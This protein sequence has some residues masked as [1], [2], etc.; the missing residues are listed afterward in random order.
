MK[1][2][3]LDNDNISSSNIKYSLEQEDY[4]VEIARSFSDSIAKLK[5]TEYDMMLLDTDVDEKNGVSIIQRLRKHSNVPLIVT[6][7]TQEPINRILAL[8]YGADDY[9]EKPFNILELKVRIKAILRRI[10]NVEYEHDREITFGD[11]RLKTIGRI[12]IRGNEVVNLTGKEFDL[13]YVLASNPGKV[14][15]RE[16]LMTEVWGY[17]YFGDLRS[18]DVHIRRLRGKLEAS[19]GGS[20]FILTKWGIGYYF[21]EKIDDAYEG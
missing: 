2:L 20:N 9:L 5:K 13:L 10:K 12:L 14:Y 4:Q 11:Y 15:S 1:V 8:E 16:D 3:I 21:N 7:S 19:G 18:I 6:S 17:Q